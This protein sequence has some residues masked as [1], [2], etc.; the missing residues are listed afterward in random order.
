MSCQS[1]PGNDIKL[2]ATIQERFES[3]CPI[4]TVNLIK[5]L[6]LY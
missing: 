4:L 2:S 6:K 5:N 1:A 3:K